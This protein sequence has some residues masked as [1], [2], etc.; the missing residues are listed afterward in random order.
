MVVFLMIYEVFN[1]F[2]SKFYLSVFIFLIS[3]LKF[4]MKNLKMSSFEFY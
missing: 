3:I 2:I 1:F 4:Y